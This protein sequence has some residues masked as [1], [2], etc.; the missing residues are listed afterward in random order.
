[1]TREELQVLNAERIVREGRMGIEAL[2]DG[3]TLRRLMLASK[4][5]PWQREAAERLVGEAVEFA[6]LAE[7]VAQE[8]NQ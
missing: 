1:M 8:E 6:A 4:R 5:P 2:L 3:Y 7:A